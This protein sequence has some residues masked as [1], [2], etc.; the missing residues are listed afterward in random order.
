MRN[1]LS[2]LVLTVCTFMLTVPAVADTELQLRSGATWRGD[3]GDTVTVTYVERGVEITQVGELTFISERPMYITIKT[4]IAG[5]KAEK[6]VFGA[7][8]KLL[9][10]STGE[11]ES[12]EKTGDARPGNRGESG[13]FRPEGRKAAPG[14]RI[15]AGKEVPRDD[16]G[17]PIGVFMLPLEGGVGQ[18]FRHDEIIE[19]GRYIDENYGPGQTIVLFV[20]SNGGLVLEAL[21]IAEA[22]HEI[23]KRHRVVAWVDK[24]ISAGCMTAMSCYEIYFRTAATAGSV[25]TLVGSTS[26]QG[27]QVAEH[28]EHFAELAEKSGYSEHIAR[29]MKLNKHMCSYDRDEETGEVTFYGDL[30]GEFDLSTADQN[31][32][33]NSN[34]ALHAGFSKGTAD[35]GEELAELLGMPQWV[36][37]D[38]YGRRIA[39]RWADK[40]ESL[41]ERFQFINA[42]FQIKDAGADPIRRLKTQINLVKEVLRN[43]DRHERITMLSF[44]AK[45]AWEERLDEMQYQLRQMTRRR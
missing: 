25:T 42:E 23:R 2:L 30:R 16:Q 26:L 39:K 10:T 20:N 22:I 35:T 15:G 34:N 8:I 5:R 27:P 14:S 45:E 13:R 24:A 17:R 41:Q 19:L 37:I 32:S 7:D 6:T 28:V 21:D 3:V 33:F 29:S 4:D 9:E 31:L 44:G 1:L 43:F 18:T 11:E 36:E 40:Y 12:G 38:D